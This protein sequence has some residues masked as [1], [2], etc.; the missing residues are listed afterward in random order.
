MKPAF[1]K[2]IYPER[3]PEHALLSASGSQNKP[4]H[5]SSFLEIT[6]CLDIKVQDKHHFPQISSCVLGFGPA[7]GW[8]ATHSEPGLAGAHRSIIPARGV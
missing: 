1:N 8:V 3:Y 4:S 6:R 2:P 7:L 5:L